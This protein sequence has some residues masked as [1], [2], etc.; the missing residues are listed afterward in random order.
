MV[1]GTTGGTGQEMEE[2]LSGVLQ[3][4]EADARGRGRARLMV[5]D[6]GG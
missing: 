6:G 4:V 3:R 5:V 2:I 1:R